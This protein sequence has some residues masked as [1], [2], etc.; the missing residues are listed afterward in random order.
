LRIVS[1]FILFLLSAGNARPSDLFF[2][3]G[4]IV[5]LTLFV[6][7]AASLAY[8]WTRAPVRTAA[9]KWE[10]AALSLLLVNAVVQQTGG[11]HSYFLTLYPV[12][13]LVASFQFSF[14]RSMILVSGIF[15]LE[16]GLF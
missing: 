9:M 10:G 12:V 3:P 2:S 14:F 8:R 13:L 6:Y 15:F 4:R 5:W 7:L 16:G 1:L 11:I